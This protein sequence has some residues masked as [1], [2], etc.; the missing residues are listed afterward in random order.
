MNTQAAVIA[1]TGIVT[2]LALASRW[3]WATR[4]AVS[5]VGEVSV[6]F[7]SLRPKQLFTQHQWWGQWPGAVWRWG[8]QQDSGNNDEGLADGPSPL[9]CTLQMRLMQCHK[10]PGPG[11]ESGIKAVLDVTHQKSSVPEDRCRSYLLPLERSWEAWGHGEPALWIYQQCVGVGR[12]CSAEFF[13]PGIN[14][15]QGGNPLLDVLCGLWHLLFSLVQYVLTLKYVL[16]WHSPMP[17]HFQEHF[18]SRCSMRSSIVSAHSGFWCVTS[19]LP[20]TANGTVILFLGLN[21][22]DLTVLSNSIFFFLQK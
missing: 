1:V 10:S 14:G 8:L 7:A 2:C 19:W 5:A 3:A 12:K 9:G 22:A 13:L 15:M 6:E 20:A 16:I 17:L 4:L 18:I 21:S 11:D